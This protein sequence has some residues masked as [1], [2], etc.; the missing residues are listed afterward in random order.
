MKTEQDSML[1]AIGA[2]P[3]C[4]RCRFVDALRQLTTH[5]ELRVRGI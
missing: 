3:K 2:L 1:F 5:Q 4:H